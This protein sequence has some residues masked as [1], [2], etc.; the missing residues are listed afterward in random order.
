MIAKA[1]C[2][3]NNRIIFRTALFT[4]FLI[5]FLISKGIVFV[6]RFL[7]IKFELFLDL[8]FKHTLEG[9]QTAGT[10]GVLLI[11]I[12][13]VLVERYWE[14]TVGRIVVDSALLERH[15]RLV[16]AEFALEAAYARL[17][18]GDHQESEARRKHPDKVLPQKRLFGLLAGDL[19]EEN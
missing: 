19:R 7:I 13:P 16:D 6:K 10:Y 5:V 14:R 1:K 4:L 15:D 9:E 11:I 18:V 2:N 8:I 17:E 12:S 3:I